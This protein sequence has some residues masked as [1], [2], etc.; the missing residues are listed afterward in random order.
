MSTEF[1][2]QHNVNPSNQPLINA[3]LS[4]NS[5][6]G[7]AAQPGG[8][9]IGNSTDKSSSAAQPTDSTDK[10]SSSA[11]PTDSTDKSSSSAEPSECYR[12]GLMLYN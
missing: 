12:S 6:N 11:Q 4:G 8:N 1:T 3:S 2:E 10:S 5:L 9:E 7:S